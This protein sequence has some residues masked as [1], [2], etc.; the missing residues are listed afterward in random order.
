MRRWL[1]T[2][3]IFLLAGAAVNVAVAWGN[4]VAVALMTQGNSL[5]KL[6]VQ[7]VLTEDERPWPHPVPSN[8]PDTSHLK[9]FKYFGW[10]CDVRRSSIETST[11]WLCA[12]GTVKAGWPVRALE[13][14]RWSET[15][16]GPDTFRY[17]V[18]DRR[19]DTGVPLDSPPP[20]HNLPFPWWTDG[21][22]LPNSGPWYRQSLPTRPL[23]PGFAVNTLFYAAFL[24]LMICGP[25]VLRR[26]SRIRRD[27]C[28][29]CGY[30][31]GDSPSCTECGKPLPRRAVA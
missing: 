9:R 3:L 30:P 28:P 26:F 25:F 5:A 12:L 11:I 2:I 8:W 23:W 6:D 29:K 7:T 17:V 1:I 10:R 14:I 22:L 19:I 24:C 27:L 15:Q 13:S 21:I 18:W 31:I 16:R 20:G 4:V